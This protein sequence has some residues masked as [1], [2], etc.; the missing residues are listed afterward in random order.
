MMSSPF[1]YRFVPVAAILLLVIGVSACKPIC[2]PQAKSGLEAATLPT[3]MIA[4]STQQPEGRDMPKLGVIIGI[5]LMAVGL[6]GCGLCPERDGLTIASASQY[7]ER[8]VVGP[9]GNGTL[10]YLVPFDAWVDNP[11]V[12]TF[13]RKVV[14]QEGRAALVSSYGFQCKA[15]PTS[16]CPDCSSCTRTMPRIRDNY[17]SFIGC[18]NDGV[19]R[20]QA[21][22]GP[23]SNVRAMTYWQK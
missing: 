2:L 13:L 11:T 9:N 15:A 17:Y 5:L 22:V 12:A 18:V 3:V 6:S 14:E 4:F 10:K 23:G 21:N 1:R 19:M 8:S 7:H 16:D 20:L